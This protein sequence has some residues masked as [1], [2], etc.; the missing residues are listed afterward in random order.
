LLHFDEGQFI[1]K[2]VNSWLISSARYIISKELSFFS[3][4]CKQDGLFTRLYKKCY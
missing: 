1:I 4:D 3:R 2:E